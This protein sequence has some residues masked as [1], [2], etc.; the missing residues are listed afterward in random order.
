MAFVIAAPSSGAGK[1]LLSLILSSWV[2]YKGKTIQTFKV[3]PDYLDPQQLSLVSKRPCRNLD[4]ILSGRN[5]VE[6][7]F[8]GFSNSAEFTLIEGV[9]G[10]FDGLGSSRKGSTADIAR[11]LDLPVVLIVDAKGQA[12]SLASSVKGFRDEDKHLK[13]AGVVLNNVSTLRHQKLLVEVLRNINIIL[14]L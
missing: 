7:S 11:L 13:I 5:W 9:M 14:T 12:A 1:T 4:L 3:G 8:Y 2:S 6:D 10:L